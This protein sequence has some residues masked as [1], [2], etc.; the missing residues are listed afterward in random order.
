VKIFLFKYFQGLAVIII[1]AMLISSCQRPKALDPEEAVKAI[2]VL[3]SD[4]ITLSDGIQDNPAFSALKFLVVEP[5]SPLSLE[6]GFTGKWLNDTITSF[7]QYTGSY[8]WNDSGFF[9]RSGNSDSIK[10]NFSNR[11]T[12]LNECQ[13]L[14]TS[15]NCRRLNTGLCFPADFKAIMTDEGEEILRINQNTDFQDNMRFYTELE[16]IGDQFEATFKADR[17]RQGDNGTLDIHIDFRVRGHEIIAGTVKAEIGYSGNQFFFK[18]IKP[19]LAIF[20]VTIR[21]FLDYGKVDPTS[22]DYV[23]SFNDHCRIDFYDSKSGKKIGDFGIGKLKNGEL[24]GWVI[25][26]DDGTQVFLEEYLLVVEK[27]FNYK[28]PDKRVEN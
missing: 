2:K 5:S 4:L 21:G 10:I 6:N 13:F 16:L 14:M 24:L 18:T 25:I 27:L 1:T 23:N 8:S 15:F 12:G 3:N 11:K 20:D 19:D 26:L 17:T 22:K 28:L 7:N 9:Q